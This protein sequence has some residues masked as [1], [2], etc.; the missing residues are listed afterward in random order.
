[1][2]DACI[3]GEMERSRERDRFGGGNRELVEEVETGLG[4]VLDSGKSDVPSNEC[5]LRIAGAT[6][7]EGSNR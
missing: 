7:G 2:M 6:M 5:S 1:M 4:L 3:R